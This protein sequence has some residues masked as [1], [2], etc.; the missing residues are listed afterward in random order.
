MN[1]SFSI[2]NLLRQFPQPLGGNPGSLLMP[3]P[4]ILPNAGQMMQM[5]NGSLFP[6]PSMD[7]LSS[8]AFQSPSV[9]SNSNSPNTNIGGGPTAFTPVSPFFGGVFPPN[10]YLTNGIEEQLSVLETTFSGTQYPDVGV[11]EKL[12]VQCDLKEERVEV[13]FKNRRAKERK[14][15]RDASISLTNSSLNSNNG[16]QQQNG[17]R[18]S[19]DGNSKLNSSDSSDEGEEEDDD[20]GS[21]SISPNQKDSQ[22][23]LHH[24]SLKRKCLEPILSPND[25]YSTLQNSA[26]KN[27]RL[28][29]PAKTNEIAQPQVKA[30]NIF[31]LS[32]QIDSEKCQEKLAPRRAS[33]MELIKKQKQKQAKPTAVKK[34]FCP[35]QY[36]MDVMNNRQIEIPGVE[37]YE[38]EKLAKTPENHLVSSKPV[39]NNNTVDRRLEGPKKEHVNAHPFPSNFLQANNPHL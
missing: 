15:N 29:S 30:E 13:W 19:S 8:Y 23:E 24:T 6:M 14:K 1:S 7:F 31:E 3:P 18:A 10:P 17:S 16:R 26:H 34:N 4:M 32:G 20:S 39:C 11:R 12:A 5:P 36:V 9:S 28:T 35:V 21:H 22:Q 33:L 27:P 25:S 37:K 2:E 38:V